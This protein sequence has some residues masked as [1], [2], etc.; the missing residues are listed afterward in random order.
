MPYVID[1]PNVRGRKKRFKSEAEARR[2]LK[3]AK[4]EGDIEEKR[5]LRGAKVVKVGGKKKR[6]ASKSFLGF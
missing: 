3:L 5:E 2:L 4:R 6:N 1:G